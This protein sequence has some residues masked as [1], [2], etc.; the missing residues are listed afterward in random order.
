MQYKRNQIPGLSVR[1]WFVFGHY[2]IA[3]NATL[4]TPCLLDLRESV[5]PTPQQGLFSVYYLYQCLPCLSQ[6]AELDATCER[7]Q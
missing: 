6:A 3:Y 2:T 7:W 5:S 1:I 4:R